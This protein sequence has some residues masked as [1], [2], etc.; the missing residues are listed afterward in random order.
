MLRFDKGTYLSLLFKFIK[1]SNSLRG[2]DVL[3]IPEFINVVS[4]LLYNYFWILILKIISKYFIIYIFLLAIIS[5]LNTCCNFNL[6]F[7]CLV[8]SATISGVGSRV[9]PVLEFYLNVLLEIICF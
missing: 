9:G 5:Y 6:D 4:I 3:L 8:G 1:L 7:L 2:S